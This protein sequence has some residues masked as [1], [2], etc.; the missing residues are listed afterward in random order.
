MLPVS[1]NNFRAIST[2]PDFLRYQGLPA[3]ARDY[4]YPSAGSSPPTVLPVWNPSSPYHG[5]PASARKP[6]RGF[7]F[8]TVNGLRTNEYKTAM[9]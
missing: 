1:Y 2:T 4:P 9:E 5:D 8:E 6:A 7:W 3:A